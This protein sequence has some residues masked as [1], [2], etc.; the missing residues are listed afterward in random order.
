MDARGKWH[1]SIAQGIVNLKSY[2]PVKV[3]FRNEG[4]IK[5]FSDERTC[6]RQTSPKRMAEAGSRCRKEAI[7][8][9]SLAT[10]GGEKRTR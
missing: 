6:L 2:N 8:D 4:E 7:E 5:E 10:S 9:S 3:F 1:F